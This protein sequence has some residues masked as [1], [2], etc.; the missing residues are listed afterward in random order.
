MFSVI[1]WRA[2]NTMLHKAQVSNFLCTCCAYDSVPETDGMGTEVEMNYSQT[3][4]ELS[5]NAIDTEPQYLI[6]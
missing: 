1:A 2:Y 5:Q 6:E 4:L 3:M